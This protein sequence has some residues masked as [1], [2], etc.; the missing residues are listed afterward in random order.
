MT[1]KPTPTFYVFH[2]D[3]D[4]SVDEAVAKLRKGMGDGPNA[5]L[6]ISE[7]DGALASVPEVINAVTSY[8]FLADKRLVIVRGMLTRKGAGTKAMFDQL[9]AELPN[10]P[11]YARLVFV[12]RESLADNHTV[13]KIA[14]S[15]D[16]GYVK[17]FAVPGDTTAWI[18]KRARSEYDAEIDQRAAA[19]LSAVTGTDLRRADNEL[20]KLVSYVGGERTI[21]EEDVAA[22]TPYVAEANIFRMVDALAE[23]QGQVALELLHRLM[24][25]RDQDPFSVFGM[26]IRQF[27][28]LLLAKE[29]L[30]TGGT[31]GT[32]ASAVGV[33]PYQAQ[34]LARQSR[35]FDVAALER[36]Y[37]ALHDYDLKMKTGQMRPH[38]ALDLFVASV[39]R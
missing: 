27:R 33:R 1:S 4:L 24:A 12:E 10:L 7:F 21:T 6:N 2:G 8:P 29:H 22:L 15:A 16:N 35:A 11:E 38:L 18:L 17:A 31:P 23:G 13:V 25:D 20:T 3:D 19:A 36:V 9:A 30:A 37:R 5:D 26:I 39:S 34:N 28:L 14:G 32:I